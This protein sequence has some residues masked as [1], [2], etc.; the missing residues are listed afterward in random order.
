MNIL[1]VEDDKLLTD[2]IVRRLAKEKLEVRVAV[3]V[4]EGLKAIEEKSPN[5]ILLDLI[6]PGVDGFSFLSQL[7]KNPK[8]NSTPIIIL[9]NISNKE[10]I[11]RAMSLGA[12]DFLIK[13]DFS[14]GGIADKIRGVLLKK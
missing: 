2:L 10:E 5:L 9:S 12:T 4:E 1:V 11:E 14:L 8:T 6:L 7:R 13:A 3:D